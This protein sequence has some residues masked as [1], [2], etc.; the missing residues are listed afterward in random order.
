[1]TGNGSSGYWLTSQLGTGDWENMF[2]SKKVEQVYICT[3]NFYYIDGGTA[4][5]AQDPLTWYVAHA[6][7][8]STADYSSLIILLLKQLM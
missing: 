3:T 6:T 2:M 7:V 5:T 1:L 4:P 8:Y